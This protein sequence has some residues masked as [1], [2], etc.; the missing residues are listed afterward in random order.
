VL[1]VRLTTQKKARTI[2]T[3]T[4]QR[5]TIKNSVGQNLNF[6][7]IGDATLIARWFARRYQW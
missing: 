7:V 6:D 4:S 5:R 1:I 3:V 2:F